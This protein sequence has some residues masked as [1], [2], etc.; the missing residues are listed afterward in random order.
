MSLFYIFA[1]DMMLEKA[2]KVFFQLIIAM[3][4]VNVCN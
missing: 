2:I 4:D 3:N 1:L